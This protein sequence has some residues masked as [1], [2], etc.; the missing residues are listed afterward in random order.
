MV[1]RALGNKNLS[2]PDGYIMRAEEKGLT[3]NLSKE[4][5]N[6]DFLTRGDVA[7]ILYNAIS[8]VNDHMLDG[9]KI[10]FVG[11]SLTYYG[12]MVYNL[13]IG[14]YFSE[15]IADIFNHTFVIFYR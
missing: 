10:L 7:I 4:I 9:K 8:P 11:N 2:Y 13:N 15:H 5:E 12:N 1:L 3:S 6:N 14:V